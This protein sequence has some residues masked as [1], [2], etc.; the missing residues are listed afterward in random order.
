MTKR[1]D[2]YKTVKLDLDEKMADEFNKMTKRDV[3]EKFM[4]AA[5][6][7]HVAKFKL[8]EARMELATAKRM[9]ESV[10]GKWGVDGKS[11]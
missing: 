11:T 8:Q 2:D 9:I 7:A 3:I 6:E 4:V 1:K 10:I 5:L